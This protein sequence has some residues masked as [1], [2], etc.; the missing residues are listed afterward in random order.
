VPQ[1]EMHIVDFNE[2]LNVDGVYGINITAW[3]IDPSF[4]LDS[5]AFAASIYQ[6]A[7]FYLRDTTTN[8]RIF[9]GHSYKDNNPVVV[10]RESYDIIY[11][12]LNGDQTPQNTNSVLRVL[13]L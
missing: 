4:T 6:S 8:K 13:D 3:R 12:H 1:N 5:L 9:L 7:T 11:E 2:V 10:V